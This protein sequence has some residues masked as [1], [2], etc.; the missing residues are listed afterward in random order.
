MALYFAFVSFYA[1]ALGPLSVIG[2]VFWLGS[3]GELD[4][5]LPCRSARS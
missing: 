3:K 4:T 2:A 1:R 5:Y